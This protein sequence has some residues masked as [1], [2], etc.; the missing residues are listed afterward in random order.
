MFS[1][2]GAQIVGMGKDICQK[3]SS[4][5]TLFQKADSIL[6]YSLS[7]IIFDG[8]AE[9]LMQ[10][11]V[12]QPAL[13]VHGLAMLAAVKSAMP[14]FHFIAVAGLSLGEFTAHV[15]AGTFDFETGLRLVL[16]R[17]KFMQEACEQK[18]G[19][20][21]AVIGA[22]EASMYDL[23]RITNVDIA[24]FNCP[25]QLVISGAQ[26]SIARAIA[27]AKK[28]GARKVVKLQV[29]GAFHSRLMEAAYQ[30]LKKELAVVPINSPSVPI[31]CNVDASPIYEPT[32]IRSALARQLIASVRWTQS[33]ECLLDYLKCDTLL[34]LGPNDVLAGLARRIRKGIRILSIYNTSTLQRALQAI[35]LL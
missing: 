35:P 32:A 24:N 34:E 30:R 16:Q 5:A 1:G 8:P 19:E 25:G 31:V 33:V 20:M 7:R 9:E 12:C 28:H 2:Q 29:A 21:A 6:K 27:L 15:A 13:Y 3:Y 11:T 18:K 26:S 23:A 4:A 22:D 14:N 17:S 10:T